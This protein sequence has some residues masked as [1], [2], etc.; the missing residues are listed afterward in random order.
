M[1]E[2]R[3]TVTAL[4]DALRRFIDARSAALLDGRRELGLGELDARALLHIA[5][6]PG[7]RPTE[8]REHLG[9]TSAGVTTLVDR[10][11]Q[12]H[13]VRREPD[14]DDRR[15]NRLS[16][17][18]DLGAPPWSALT[19]FDAD[20]ERVAGDL[21]ARDADRLAGMLD[22]VVRLTSEGTTATR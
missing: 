9:I 10:L 7:V 22:D 3:T 20:L 16:V 5:A 18:V 8:L 1:D 12:R 13:A 11:V 2:L 15:V 19:R 21:D 4:P 17:V 6:N 14:P